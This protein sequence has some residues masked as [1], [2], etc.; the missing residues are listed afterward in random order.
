[1]IY[2]VSSSKVR[3]ERWFESR[4]DAIA[5]FERKCKRLGI[6]A[7][8]HYPPGQSGDCVSSNLLAYPRRTCATRL[9]DGHGYVF[10]EKRNQ[11][12]L[13]RAAAVR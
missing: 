10:V 7:P 13:Q 6:P 2:E 12:Q 1:V 8:L 9:R 11:T 3:I 5:A 4:E